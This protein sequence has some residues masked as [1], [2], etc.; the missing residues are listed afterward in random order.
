MAILNV[1]EWNLLSNCSK[2]VTTVNAE[3]VPRIVYS[4]F[5]SRCYKA[6]S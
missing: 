6:P 4:C 5:N 1:N 2:K 3:P